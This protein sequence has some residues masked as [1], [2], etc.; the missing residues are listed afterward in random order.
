MREL[1]FIAS[2]YFALALLALCSYIFGRRL[3]QRVGYH[4]F[5][6]QASF[7]L[8]LGLGVIAYLILFLGLLGLLYRSLLIVGLLLG[9]LIC[10]PVWLRWIREL[11]ALPEKLRAVRTRRL[12]IILIGGVIALVVSLPVWI[13]PLYPPSNSDA[14]MYHLPTAR[15]YAEQHALVHTPYLRYPVLP[16][17]N[18]MLFT[19]ALLFY[20][21]SLAQ[22]VELLMMVTLAASVVAFG[23]RYFSTR[24]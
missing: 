4:S 5:L 17:T 12:T 16:Q 7:S 8:T 1:K 20:D 23:Q 18:Q 19:L 24:V 22:L 11:P 9:L 3:T 6:E 13:R 10:Y 14:T 21:D 2:H 15:T